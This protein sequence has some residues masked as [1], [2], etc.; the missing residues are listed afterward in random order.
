VNSRDVARFHRCTTDSLQRLAETR[1]V[2][3]QAKALLART[4]ERL[5]RDH[6]LRADNVVP[7]ERLEPA[8]QVRHP[9]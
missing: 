3:D 8:E 4:R 6:P 1:T 5:V 2:I 7:E 9:L